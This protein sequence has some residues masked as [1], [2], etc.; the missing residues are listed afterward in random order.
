MAAW[1]FA[2]AE[3]YEAWIDAVLE[4]TNGRRGPRWLEELSA[5]RPLSAA[6]LPEFRELRLRVNSHGNIQVQRNTYSMPPRLRGERVVVRLSEMRLEVFYGGQRQLATER[7][8]GEGKHRIDYRH[9]IGSLLRKPGAFA[10]YR[11]RDALYPAPA[12]RQAYDSLIAA[13]PERQAEIEYLRVLH[14]A[15]TTMQCDV[16]AGLELLLAEQRLPRV[17]DLRALIGERV[18]QIPAMAPLIVD[19]SSYDALLSA[20][21]AR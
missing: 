3:A 12:F 14:L 8:R 11:Y 20:A 1:D 5:M 17:A 21:V 16:E 7:L 9:V 13:L 4:R 19:L 15:A 10:R 6:R 18:P 2:S